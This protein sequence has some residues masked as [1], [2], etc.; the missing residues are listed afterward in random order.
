MTLSAH[1][2]VG[3]EKSYNKSGFQTN[4]LLY[5]GATATTYTKGT[6]LGI[7]PAGQA[8]AG[9][10]TSITGA[11]TVGVAMQIAGVAAE[12]K[13]TTDSNKHVKVW[14]VKDE[15]FTVSFTDHADVTASATSTAKNHFNTTLASNSTLAIGS[16]IYIYEGPG[17]GD[18]KVITASSTANNR[19]TVS[20]EFSALPTTASKAI[21]LAPISTASTVSAGANVGSQLRVSTGSASKVSVK[22]AAVGIGYVNVL[23]IDH[24][25]LT[26]DVRIAP[27]KSLIGQG[28]TAT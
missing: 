14:P 7:I 10:L 27:A 15:V 8:S 23:G 5:E 2:T 28:N 4:P 19:F 1:N 11:S 16:P 21:I 22:S 25:N 3:F 13:T 18:V 12:T 26:M 24:K 9:L 6:L 20:G 17:K